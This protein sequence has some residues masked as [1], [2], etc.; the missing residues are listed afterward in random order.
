[1][2]NLFLEGRPCSYGFTRCSCLTG[3]SE[4]QERVQGPERGPVLW[5]H[6]VE[7]VQSL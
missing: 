2:I 3:Q 7:V 6:C 5:R 1:M 4:E